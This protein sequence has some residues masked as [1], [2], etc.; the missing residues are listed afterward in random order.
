MLH[1]RITLST[2]AEMDVYAPPS[3]VDS[4]ARKKAIVICPGG[5]YAH[6]SLREAEPVA[7]RFA[8]MGFVTFVLWYHVA[9]E[10][11]PRAVQDVGAAVAYIRDHHEVLHADAQAIAVMGFSAGAHAACSL[12][13]M[14]QDGSLWAPLG[15]TCAQVRPNAMVLGY[16]VITAGAYAHR[17]SMEKLTG[18]SDLAVH[19]RFSLEE[20][21]T[22]QTPP[23]FLWH[24]WDDQ[25][26]PVENT[27][28]MASTL[29]RCHVQA[30]VHIY[31]HGH[32]GSA[33]CDETS[34]SNGYYLIPD[35]AE[36]PTRAAAFLKN[37]M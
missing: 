22:E 8:S 37:V 25:A 35:A 9:P 28:L 36:W 10:V 4:S 5:G 30:E 34:D 11:F 24:T 20:H 32:H 12:G 19:A 17:G 14:W 27:L 13:V 15:L 18:S 33:L 2:G 7:L 23:T 6:L 29:S 26:V 16:P 21:V 31:P 1:Q 3:P